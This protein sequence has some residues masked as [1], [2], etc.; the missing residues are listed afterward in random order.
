MLPNAEPP[1]VE[2]RDNRGLLETE[3]MCELRLEEMK[4]VVPQMFYPPYV[5]GGK[6]EQIGEQL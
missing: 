6:C 2:L 3:Q 5:V 1:C 4:D